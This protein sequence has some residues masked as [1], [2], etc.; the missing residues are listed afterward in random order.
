MKGSMSA[1]WGYQAEPTREEALQPIFEQGDLRDPARVDA[2]FAKYAQ[3]EAG[4]IWAVIHLAA[5][6]AVGESGEKPVQYYQVNVAGSLN[7]LE[8]SLVGVCCSHKGD[9]HWR[10]AYML[11]IC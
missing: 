1:Q 9:W 8:V 4:G 7:L 11:D 2:V 10:M 6:K 5:L 3:H